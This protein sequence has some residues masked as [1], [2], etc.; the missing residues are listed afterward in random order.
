[1]EKLTIKPWQVMQAHENGAKIEMDLEL[2]WLTETDP[3]WNWNDYNFRIANL[4]ADGIRLDE[5]VEKYPEKI[6]MKPTK[7]GMGFMLTGE[8]YLTGYLIQLLVEHPEEIK[9]VIVK[10]EEKKLRP[11]TMAEFEK[12]RDEWFVSKSGSKRKI[13][14][15]NDN[16]LIPAWYEASVTYKEFMESF[17]REDGSPCGVLE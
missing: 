6:T 5:L 9:H 10:G 15:F 13:I 8:E 12:H 11:W 7:S 1:M 2:A 3:T 14:H 17:N 16:T 4:T